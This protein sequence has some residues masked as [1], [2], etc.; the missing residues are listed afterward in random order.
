MGRGPGSPCAG[1]GHGSASLRWGSQAQ[2][3]RPGLDG[4]AMATCRE[5]VGDPQ[6]VQVT[7]RNHLKD[8]YFCSVEK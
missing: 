4:K 2:S 1:P 3:L 8:N 5:L 7:L 6:A